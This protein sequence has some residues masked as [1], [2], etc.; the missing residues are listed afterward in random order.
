MEWLAFKTILSL[1]F[2]LLLMGVVLFLL[3]KILLSKGTTS[4]SGV[5]MQVVGTLSLQPKKT[6]HIIK[7]VDKYFVVGISDQGI[8][9]L[10]ELSDVETLETIRK[11]EQASLVSSK[12]FT[13]YFSEY[14]GVIGWRNGKKAY[15]KERDPLAS[16]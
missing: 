1:L 14:L 5:S 16:K 8:H 4:F 11:Y 15:N 13:D 10:S 6:I 2:V 9:M 3:K 12:T 7:I